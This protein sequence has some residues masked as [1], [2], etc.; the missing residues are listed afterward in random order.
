MHKTFLMS[1]SDKRDDR[2]THGQTDTWTH[3]H[4]DIQLPPLDKRYSP[5]ISSICE[6]NNNLPVETQRGHI[7]YSVILPH[8]LAT[9]TF[10]RRL[11]HDHF[12]KL[13]FCKKIKC[14]G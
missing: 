12:L 8:K 5:I 6:P 3:G 11:S 13:I 10:W 14:I 2:R 7:E 1:F 4:T 9:N